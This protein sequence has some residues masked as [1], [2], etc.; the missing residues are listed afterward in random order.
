M[1]KPENYNSLSPYF[2]V[3]GALK[4]V[5]LLD[6]IFEVEELR[7]YEDENEEILHGEIR[8]EDTVIMVANSNDEYP[9]NQ[10]LVHVYVQDVDATYKKAIDAG[11]EPLQEPKVSD[12]DTDKRGM[13]KDFAGNTW[14]IATQL[15]AE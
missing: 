4:F 1:F 8:I 14:A 3:D 13:F 15:R 6:E 2:V 10:M 12:A 7:T 5:D 11:C 9:P